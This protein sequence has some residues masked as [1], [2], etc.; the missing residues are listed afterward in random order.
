MYRMNVTLQIFSCVISIIIQTSI[1]RALY[2][3][4]EMVET[5]QGDISLREMTIYVI[6]STILSL[7]I[8]NN[9][10][11]KLEG[12]I[13][14]GEIATDLIKPLDL[15]LLILSDTIGNSFF[16]ITFQV[17]PFILVAI[18]VLNINAPHFANLIFFV[19]ALINAFFLYYILT[20]LIGLLAFWYTSV[21]HL[22]RFLSDLIGLLSGSIIPLWF[23]PEILQ[24]LAVFFPF[25]LIYYA[26]IT[27]YLEKVSFNETISLILQQWLWIGLLVLIER[28]VWNK[29]VHK[30]SVQGG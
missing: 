17:V 29:A 27:I 26:A 5:H 3:G 11:W 30:L 9:V 24:Q 15:K 25:K 22:N 19:I 13:R 1:W 28:I 10:I 8:K 23:F 18:F 16:K 4:S 20:Y 21:W 6:I 7:I 12:K 2:A 14:S